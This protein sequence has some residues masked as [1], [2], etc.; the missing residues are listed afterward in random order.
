MGEHFFLQYFFNLRRKTFKAECTV[1]IF[2]KMDERKVLK[3]RKIAIQSF[4]YFYLLLV[5]V[6]Y[7]IKGSLYI[8]EVWCKKRTTCLGS[9]KDGLFQIVVALPRGAKANKVAVADITADIIRQSKHTLRIF[10]KCWTKSERNWNEKSKFQFFWVFFFK[11]IWKR[12]CWSMFFS[13][14]SCF[15]INSEAFPKKIS[16]KIQ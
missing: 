15:V 6:T 8:R 4:S 16:R 14:F 7:L 9:R 11:Q 10:I 1:W 3:M 2:K 12:I 13:F 5:V